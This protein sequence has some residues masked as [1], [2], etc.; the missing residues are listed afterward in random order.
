MNIAA[1]IF[2][3]ENGWLFGLLFFPTSF[4]S[5]PLPS[6]FRLF[7]IFHSSHQNLG[8]ERNSD[9]RSPKES[10]AII[11]SGEQLRTR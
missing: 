4:A 8:T 5:L 2:R 6:P 10:T 3:C 7:I 11:S 1:V 9:V